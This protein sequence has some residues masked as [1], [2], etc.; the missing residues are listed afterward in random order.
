M[1]ILAF[2]FLFSPFKSAGQEVQALVFYWLVPELWKK[3]LIFS[4]IGFCLSS[5]VYMWLRFY[6]PAIL[7]FSEK[8]IHIRGWGIKL[9]I[10]IASIRKIYCNDAATIEVR[11]KQKLSIIIEHKRKRKATAI[12]LKNYYQSDPF[13]E[14]LMKYEGLELKFYDFAF[15]P[16]HVDEN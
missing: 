8:E 11:S 13:M 1:V 9:T 12:Q 6:K 2:D 5:V 15:N 14:Q 10:P 16:I 7:S 4:A 3:V